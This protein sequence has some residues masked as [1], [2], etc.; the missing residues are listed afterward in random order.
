MA[1]DPS[2]YEKAMPIVAA[3]LA[4]I[5][6]AVNRTRASHA[7]QPFEAV[8]QALTEALQDE[9][10]QRVVPQVVEELARQISAVEAGPSG[11]AG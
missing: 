1:V 11:A 9:V 2:E 3:H 5:E 8:H 4:K 6:R 10:A 7:G